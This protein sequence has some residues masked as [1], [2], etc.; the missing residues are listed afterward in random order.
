MKM[1]MLFAV[2]AR[3]MLSE[4]SS[5]HKASKESHRLMP[6]SEPRTHQYAR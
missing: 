6:T 2:L 1:I 4:V 5:A 3:V